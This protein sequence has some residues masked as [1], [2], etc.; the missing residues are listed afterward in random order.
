MHTTKTHRAEPVTS[1]EMRRG[2]RRGFSEAAPDLPRGATAPRRDG[3]ARSP[4]TGGPRAGVGIWRSMPGRSLHGPELQ[5]LAQA[6]HAA[7]TS[8][9]FICFPPGLTEDPP[10]GLSLAGWEVCAH[11]PT[12][13]REKRMSA[14]AWP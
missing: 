4:C 2:L 7:A 14:A 8:M 11:L 3:H 10:T 1:P 12:A 5:T 9:F 13:S 6:L